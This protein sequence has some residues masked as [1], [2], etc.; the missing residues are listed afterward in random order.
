MGSK[1]NSYYTKIDGSYDINKEENNIN[2]RKE[3]HTETLP[4]MCIYHIF[5]KAN[6]ATSTNWVYSDRQIIDYLCYAIGVGP[7]KNLITQ[8]KKKSLLVI[9]NTAHDW[10]FRFMLTP[11]YGESVYNRRSGY[12]INSKEGF[13][14]SHLLYF[15]KDIKYSDD[16]Q[17]SYILNQLTIQIN[18]QQS[19]NNE[20]VLQRQYMNDIFIA[21][22]GEDKIMVEKLKQCLESHGLKVYVDSKIEDGNYWA[23]IV[24]N[25]KNSAYFM[26]YITDDYLTKAIKYKRRK[27]V[28]DELGVNENLGI[29][30]NEKD[31]VSMDIVYNIS[32]KLSGVAT[33]LILAEYLLKIDFRNTYSIPVIENQIWLVET[34]IEQRSDGGALPK[35]LFSSQQMKRFYDGCVDPFNGKFNYNKYIQHAE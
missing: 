25:L 26:P 17:F 29:L 30:L 7:W 33:E 4:L 6:S 28:F 35:Q 22:A 23:D 1:Y 32:K 10:L 11:I 12:Y 9:G 31:P 24:Y 16:T 2:N 13:A 5:G 19:T 18:Q 3:V 27:I 34:N 20:D 14:D 21:H 15:L 8:I